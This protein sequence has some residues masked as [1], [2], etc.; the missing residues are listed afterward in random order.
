M[1]N[2][3]IVL[4]FVLT[5]W[6]GACREKEVGPDL[7]TPLTGQ[8]GVSYLIVNLSAGVSNSGPGANATVELR[9]KNNNTLTVTV[10]INDAQIQISDQFDATV[11]PT[12]LDNYHLRTPGL[13]SVYE[14]TYTTS[15]RSTGKSYIN[16]FNDGTIRGSFG[17]V[18]PSDLMI[19]LGFN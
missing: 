15:D 5:L 7:T 8:F 11:T 14:V 9:R 4:A 1:K 6:L 3:S 16:L 19:S 12:S 2:R 10:K 18:N 17:Y 13:R